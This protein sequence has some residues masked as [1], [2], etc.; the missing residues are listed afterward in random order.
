MEMLIYKITNLVNGKI[1]IGQTIKTLDQRWKQHVCQVKYVKQKNNRKICR[2]LHTAISKYGINNFKIEMIDWT[3]NQTELNYKE[4]LL[5]HK[6]NSLAPN[7]YNLRAGG[8]S[9]VVSQ[10]TKKLLS[11]KTAGKNNG[12]YGKKGSKKQKEWLNKFNSERIVTQEMIENM[13][14]AQQ[15]R[16]KLGLNK[17]F[18]GKKT[19]EQVEKT[20]SKLRKKYIAVSPDGFVF[21]VDNIRAFCKQ[22][23]LSN[24]ALRNAAQFNKKY[25]EWKVIER[26]APKDKDC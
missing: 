14:K 9:R 10:D 24:R 8:D 20:V 13:K 7:G 4:W 2:Y 19:P 6:F 16:S 1:Y 12:M 22:N 15:L 18:V 21:R 11:L 17:G 5:I 23:N 26:P 3:T 25:K